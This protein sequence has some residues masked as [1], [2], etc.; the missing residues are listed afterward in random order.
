MRNLDEIIEKFIELKDEFE[1][2]GYGEIHD[3]IYAQLMGID[4]END[5]D[6]EALI[7]DLN[8]LVDQLESHLYYITNTP[9]FNW[10]FG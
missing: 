1:D 10:I 4:Y 5:K 3:N 2:Y 8:E 9:D 7:R 6:D